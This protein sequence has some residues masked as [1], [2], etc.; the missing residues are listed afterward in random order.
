M[1]NFT[2]KQLRHFSATADEG[3][4]AGAASKLGVSATAISASLANLEADT[5]LKLFDRQVARG[6]NLTPAGR[7]YVHHA[8]HLL[9]EAEA[10]A[11]HAG[12]LA[13]AP[14]GH[15]RLGCY[16]SFA[17]LF[18]ADILRQHRQH[19]QAQP[20]AA[21]EFTEGRPERM[22]RQVAENTLD[23]TLIY[24]RPFE[25]PELEVRK[26]ASVR[27]QVILPAGHALARK[28]RIE[29]GDLAGLP[30]VMVSDPGTAYRFID[31]LREQGLSPEIALSTQSH[32]MARS[33]IGMGMGF[34][35][36]CFAPET[37]QTYAGDPLCHRPLAVP[38]PT[39][40]ILFLV[41]RNAARDPAL[42]MLADCCR[43]VIA[44]HAL[45]LE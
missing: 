3:S 18:G 39:V 36:M 37:P 19:R 9:A 42:E 27:P 41:R 8:R 7:N 30:Y 6:L 12:Q 1:N 22:L 24:A 2:L 13:Q 32:E 33:C 15:L 11:R 25:Q 40:D 5:G 34:T 31:M 43:R 17:A 4:I 29:I 44:R 21:L 35:L 45:Q 38:F 20:A 23:A 26:L 14:S 10:L 28:A 16:H